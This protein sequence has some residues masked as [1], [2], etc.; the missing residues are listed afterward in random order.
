MGADAVSRAFRL[1]YSRTFYGT[2]YYIYHQF[3][4]GLPLSRP[5]IAWDGKTP[6][7]PTCCRCSP[8]PERTC[9]DRRDGEIRRRVRASRRLDAGVVRV[10][11]AAFDDPVFRALGSRD[12][13]GRVRRRTTHDHVG[14][15][16]ARVGRCAARS[17]LRRRHA[18]QPRRA[19]VPRQGVPDGDSL[20][21][22]SRRAQLSLPDAVLPLGE[23]RARSGAR[24]RCHRRRALVAAVYAVHR[25]VEPRRL[26]PRHLSRPP[27]AA[28]RPGPRVSR[29][30]RNR[31]RRGLVGQLR[32]HLVH[33]HRH[34]MC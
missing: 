2:G 22:R 3:V 10:A 15:S 23:H 26:L 29:H 30:T 33:L 9:A 4:P 13:R 1:A 11:L 16:R 31:R 28:V 27:R 19:R 5:L 6:P 14:R 34:A 8:T 12:A 17:V 32:R 7:E 24:G 25:P 21:R 20:L 18:L